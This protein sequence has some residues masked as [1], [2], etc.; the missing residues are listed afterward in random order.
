MLVHGQQNRTHSG[1]KQ[2]L[3]LYHSSMD[4]LLTHA[5]IVTEIYSHLLSR[6]RKLLEATYK[7]YTDA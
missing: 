5:I 1:Q 6:S 2:K 3:E 7:V 4:L